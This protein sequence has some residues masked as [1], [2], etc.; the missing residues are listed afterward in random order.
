MTGGDRLLAG[1]AGPDLSCVNDEA[2]D[3]FIAILIIKQL[4][5]ELKSNNPLSATIFIH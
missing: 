3:G 2:T 5:F 1:H 4:T